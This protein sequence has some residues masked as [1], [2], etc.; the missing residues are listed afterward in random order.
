MA[1]Q[2][3]AIELESWVGAA[4]QG[5]WIAAICG[6]RL[7]AYAFDVLDRKRVVACVAVGNT[8]SALLLERLGFT[9]EK[10][11][12]KADRIHGRDIDLILYSTERR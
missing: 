5:R 8:R 1:D 12:Q 6:R 2:P 4:Y 10:L 7:I 3:H 9:R 11:L